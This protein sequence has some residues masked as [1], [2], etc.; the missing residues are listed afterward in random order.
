M[1]FTAMCDLHWELVKIKIRGGSGVLDFGFLSGS[2]ILFSAI[3]DLHWVLCKAVSM[4]FWINLS[5]SE[6]LFPEI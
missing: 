6:M 4:R 5:G 2:K 1:P 3:Y